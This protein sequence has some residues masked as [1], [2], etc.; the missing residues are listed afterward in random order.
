[1]TKD[2][3]NYEEMLTPRK[4]MSRSVAPRNHDKGIVETC[5]LNQATYKTD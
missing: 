4:G 2:G 1:M 5:A 3:R